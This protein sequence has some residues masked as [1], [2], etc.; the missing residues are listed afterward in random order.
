MRLARRAAGAIPLV[1][2]LLA[3]APVP[4]ARAQEASAGS[5]RIESFSSSITIDQDASFDAV[6]EIKAVFPDPKH[7]IDRNIPVR[8]R[9]S[10][11]FIENI[12]LTVDSVDDGQGNAYPYALS[13]QGDDLRI[14]IGDPNR[15]VTGERTYEIRYTVRRALL[16]LA[17]HDE[18]Y[19]NVSGDAWSM[20]LESVTASVLLPSGIADKD[21]TT[22]C[23]TGPTGSTAKDCVAATSDGLYVW[24]AKGPLTIAIGWPKGF[25]TA[26]TA[27]DSARDFLLDNIIFLVPILVFIAMFWTWWTRGRDPKTGTVMAEYDPPL[28][29]TPVEVAALSDMTVEPRAISATIVDLAVRGYLKIAESDGKVL[30]WDRKDYSLVRLKPADA[31]LPASENGLFE[32]IF[33]GRESVA[34]SG[35]ATDAAFQK[36]RALYQ[37]EVMKSLV[38]AGHFA[39]NPGTVRVYYVFAAVV[40]A[41]AIGV[42]AQRLESRFGFAGIFSF[43]VSAMMIA[44]FGIF[45]PRRL[46]KGA[47]AYRHA[48]GF[49]LYLKMAEKRRIEWQVTEDMFEKFL[50]YA[51]AFGVVDAWTRAFEGMTVP[52]PDW[53]EGASVASFSPVSFGTAIGGFGTAASHA[54]M[55][56]SSG[57]TGG[58]SSGGGAG[59]GGGGSW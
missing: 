44:A 33:D 52:K 15:T 12:R 31:G 4:A 8:Y 24:S 1:V 37:A 57:S 40:V 16:S 48:K 53:Y 47:E 49:K 28:G 10:H 13:T 2:A 55:P 11:G 58:G 3:F 50:P 54:T 20:P 18:L 30:L 51:M 17:D 7:G 43:I 34:V 35:L 39:K 25:V 27:L 9:D 45:M 14:R 41:T 19:W 5:E 29:M 36:A 42:S 56:S 23:Y 21:V 32:A 6:E 26:P 22:S 38:S 46:P 59:G